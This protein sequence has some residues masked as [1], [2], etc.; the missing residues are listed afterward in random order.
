[1]QPSYRT[2]HLLLGPCA[3]LVTLVCGCVRL[4]LTRPTPLPH[5]SQHPALLAVGCYD[6]TVKVFDVRKKE[7]VHI[8]MSDIRTGKHTDPVWQVITRASTPPPPQSSPH[9]HTP[10]SLP[11]APHW[12]YAVNTFT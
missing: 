1:M 6:G 3:G 7:N 4:V 2:V 10:V 8:F 11:H 12:P 5:P 9:A